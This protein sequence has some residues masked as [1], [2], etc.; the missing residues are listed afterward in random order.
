M[1]KDDVLRKKNIVPLL[2]SLLDGKKKMSELLKVI[3]NYMTIKAYI[4]DLEEEGYVK[5][6][7]KFEGRKVIY[8]ELTERG[9]VVA[10]ALKKAEWLANLP[11]DKIEKFANIKAYIHIN[12]Y[13]D[14]VTLKEIHLGETRIINVYVKPKGN[15]IYFY[16][17][18]HDSDDC[19]HVEVMFG[20]PDIS[21]Y[22][23]DWLNKNGYKLAKK[24]QKYVEKYW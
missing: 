17:D 8:V 13:E 11:P 9:R 22:I 16:C 14:H 10:E 3:P 18:Y 4:S 23:R 2:T 24:Y 19:E 7:E 21:D 15:V 12:S 5:T 1:E 6:E 20:D